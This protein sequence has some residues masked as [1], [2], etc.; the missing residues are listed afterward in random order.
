MPMDWWLKTE[1]KLRKFNGKRLQ[2][3][4]KKAGLSLDKVSKATGIS[5]CFLWEVENGFKNPG[6]ANAEKLIKLFEGK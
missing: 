5:I 4:R 6:D 3:K 1:V 2:A